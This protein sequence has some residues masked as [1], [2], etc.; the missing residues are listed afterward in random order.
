MPDSSRLSVPI[1]VDSPDRTSRRLEPVTCGIPWPRGALRDPAT[2]SMHGESDRQVPLQARTLENW[3][4]GS[5][6]W[7]LLDWQAEL[8][9]ESTARYRLEI[10]E[11]FRTRQDRPGSRFAGTLQGLAI[12]T[13]AAQF[14]IRAAETFPFEA[15][16]VAGRPAIDAARTRFTVVDE[17]G[18]TFQP[19]LDHVEL[20]EQGP[21]RVGGQARRPARARGRTAALP[22][23]RLAPFLRGTGGG[24]LR[25]DPAQPAPRRA[26][27]QLLESRR[28]GLG[29]SS[30]C[31]PDGGPASRH[32]AGAHR[33]LA[34]AFR[35]YE[36]VRLVRSRSTRTRAAGKTGA[37]RSISTGIGSCPIRFEAIG[38]ELPGKSRPACA[39]RPS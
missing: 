28:R 8:A 33:V 2:L 34:R 9:A 18:H 15:V 11:E 25:S 32:R 39:P 16:T 29:L 13:G 35:S 38:C 24:P 30:R 7:V 4:D 26:P 3:P 10:G 1:E 14:T 27:R 17:A 23:L 12:D 5:V 6:R 37:A 22:D 31:R 21:L 20:A 19:R 36:R